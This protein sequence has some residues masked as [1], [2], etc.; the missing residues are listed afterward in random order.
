MGKPVST[1]QSHAVIATFMNTVQWDRLDAETLQLIV[2]YPKEAG[3]MFTAAMMRPWTRHLRP[4]YPAYS[5]V[6]LQAP[7]KNRR[8]ME[9]GDVFTDFL[10]PAFREQ[11]FLEDD[12]SCSSQLADVWEVVE[13]GTAREILEHSD[14]RKLAFN[15]SRVV[16]I[17]EVHDELLN[18]RVAN[19]V[20]FAASGIPYV[21]GI[22]INARGRLSIGVA[23]YESDMQYPKKAHF[24]LSRTRE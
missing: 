19:Y 17:A 12:L 11:H 3:R 24:I 1:A 9:A 20:P 13:P 16:D 18:E 14:F 10:D 23:H 5:S 21:A 22:T 4:V 8:I 2:K 6:I 7:E 15:Q